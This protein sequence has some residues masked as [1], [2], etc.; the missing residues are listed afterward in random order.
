MS[1]ALHLARL[2]IAACLSLWPFAGAARAQ[3]DAGVARPALAPGGVDTAPEQPRDG[4]IL[5]DGP[6]EPPPKVQGIPYYEELARKSP[7]D[8]QVQQLLAAAYARNGRTEDARRVVRVALELA[9]DDPE[10]HQA[11]ALIEEGAG[12]FPAAE[13]AIRKAT[14]LDGNVEYRL[15]LGR[16]LYLA[17]KLADAEAE[18]TKIETDFAT[19]A[20]VLLALAD[21]ER[22]LGRTDEAATAYDK[23]LLLAPEGSPRHIDILVEKGRMLADKGRNPEALELLT[24]ARQQAPKDPDVHYNL[25]VLYVRLAQHEAAITSFREALKLDAD[26]ARA[27]N[28]M[29]VAFDKLHKGE[30]AMKAFS[31]AV[32]IDPRFADAHYNLGLASFKLRKFK[33]ARTAL[34]KALSIAPDMADAKFYLGEVYYQL[35]DSQKAL[36]VYK[37]ALR[38]NPSDAS[39]HRRLGDIHLQAADLDLAI[40]EYWAAVDADESD[41]GNRAQ[42][43]RTLLLRNGDGDAR[44]AAKLGDKGLELDKKALEIRRALAEAEVQAGRSPRAQLILE[45]GVELDQQNPKAH[46]VLGRFLLDQSTDKAITAAQAEFAIALRVDPKNAEALAGD[47]QANYALGDKKR[48][49]QRFEEALAIDPALA[50]ARA[51]LGR[52]LYEDGQNKDALKHLKR[53]ADD[54]PRL[55]KAWFYLAFAQ[56]KDGQGAAVVERSL[57]KAVDAQ[58]DLAEAHMQLGVLYQAQGKKDLACKAFVAAI[59]ARPT[60]EE[61]LQK[62][63]MLECP[64]AGK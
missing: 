54:A 33:E 15:D 40:G 9:V 49:R 7:G 60:Y 51:D 11:L 27:Q 32:E 14:A 53:A 59:A 34:E 16:I 35:G 41:A 29:G 47:G 23:A 26:M 42:L 45:E 30:D 48:A 43:M 1:R 19:N 44:R 5:S 8:A 17:G 21:A 39:S 18:W 4:A 13:E 61:A 6:T 64:A 22:E 28:N 58:P 62:R 12:T 10:M 52:L 56:N 36:R 55:G 46:V 2:V 38:S 31:K 3:A 63:E 20:E 50:S 24:R 37:E 57:R 25:G